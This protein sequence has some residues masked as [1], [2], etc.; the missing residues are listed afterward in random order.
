MK[1]DQYKVRLLAKEQ[2]LSARVGRSIESGREAADDSARD[3][4][5]ESAADEIKSERF[6]EADA[7]REV[8]TQVRD[9]LKRIADGTFGT[10]VVGGEPIEPA[11]LEAV[12]WTPYCMKHQ[13]ARERANPPRT[14]TL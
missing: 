9:A 7:D 11:R 8:L 10:C 5:D 13:Q 4:G 2:E 6:A 1:A 14:P 12:P 3:V